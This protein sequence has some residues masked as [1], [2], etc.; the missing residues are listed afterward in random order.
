MPQNS[1]AAI[2]Y[3][4]L[5]ECFG[6]R[7]RYYYIDDLVDTVNRR[8]EDL[9]CR[10]VT[11]RTIQQDIRFMRSREGYGI[12]LEQRFSGHERIYRYADPD[13]SIFRQEISPEEA[14]QLSDTI[15]MLSRF[16]GLP[17]Y[18]WLDEVLV[19]LQQ[20]FHLD[21]MEQGTVMF[22]QN[23]YLQGLEHFRPLL[24]A[25]VAKQVVVL[26]YQPY[27]RR[28]KLR[29]VHPYQLRQYNNRWY[30][31][32]LEERLRPRIPYAVIPLDRIVDVRWKRDDGRGMKSEGGGMRCEGGGMKSEGGG[33]RE[34]VRWKREDVRCGYIENTEGDFS[35]Y[36]DNI[37]GVSLLPEGKPVKVLLRAVYPAVNYIN[38]KPLHPSQRVKERGDG[39]VVYQLDVIP[40]EELVQQ[41]LVYADQLEVMNCDW[42]RGELQ[43][44]A[45]A[46]LARN[47]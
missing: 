16:K 46:I 38:T 27:G 31:V 40:N 8:L 34:D 15:Q 36:F 20:K 6:N 39:Y 47:P 1:L 43:K 5:D 45:R 42:L 33:M 3:R 41:L 7:N 18:Q 23:P 32:G 21:G 37:V 12:E 25:I 13:F 4:I 2:R 9:D 14:R 22:A 10:P 26:N 28:R 19:R 29:T 44:R 30:L 35:E 11:K 17:T 24:D